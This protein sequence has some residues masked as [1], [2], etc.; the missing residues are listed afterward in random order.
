MKLSLAPIVVLCEWTP[1]QEQLLHLP[2]NLKEMQTLGPRQSH[3]VTRPGARHK[4]GGCKPCGSRGTLKQQGGPAFLSREWSE[5]SGISFPGPTGH[6]TGQPSPVSRAFLL[7]CL[8]QGVGL[9]PLFLPS[10]SSLPT[11]R[12]WEDSRQQSWPRSSPCTDT[13]PGP[14]HLFA[15]AGWFTLS[16]FEHKGALL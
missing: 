9:W 6:W 8:T 4:A 5:S 16:H 3:C 13:A 2:K 11:P 1:N 12:T 7:C 15:H 10:A 14:C